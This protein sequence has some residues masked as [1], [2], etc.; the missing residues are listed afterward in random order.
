MTALLQA[1]KQRGWILTLV[2]RGEKGSRARGWDKLDPS[3]AEVECHVSEGGNVGV[4][5]GPRSNELVDVDHDCGE[6]LELGDLYLPVTQAEFGRASRPRSHRLFVAL[7]ATYEAFADPVDGEM[8]VELRA[9]GQTGGA[10][11]TLFPPSTADG[12]RREWYG[13]TIAPAVV[14]ARALRLSVA[15]L[16]IGCLVARYISLHAAQRPG[17]DL[18]SLL[19]EFDHVLGRA[20]FKWL[21]LPDPDAPQRYPRHRNEMSRDDLDLAE[22]VHA[23]PNNCSWDEWNSIGLAIYA[24]SHGSGDGRVIFDDFSAKLPSKYQSHAVEERWRNYSR[25]PPARTGHGKL[26]KLALAAGWHPRDDEKSQ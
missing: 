5:L 24:A 8:L 6:A 26:I 25:S 22:V 10:H 16:A 1:Y 4:L 11:Q 21:G 17:P 23:I 20:A 18:P 3:L 13:D 19:W 7:G 15:R 12:E 9:Q 2:P 14:D